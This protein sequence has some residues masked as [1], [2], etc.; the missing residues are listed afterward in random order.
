M[1]KLVLLT[2]PTLTTSAPA[3]TT[4]APPLTTSAPT[5]TTSP[6]SA[7]PLMTSAPAVTTSAPPLTTSA[8]APKAKHHRSR[9]SHMQDPKTSHDR[10]H[11][12]SHVSAQLAVQIHTW[13]RYL[14]ENQ[15]NWKEQKSKMLTGILLQCYNLNIDKTMAL[16]QW[17]MVW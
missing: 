7:P 1:L 14:T 2:T 9:E 16:L 3:V 4:S 17:K 13:E 15:L 6:T 8:P 12:R 5:I 11:D 10:S